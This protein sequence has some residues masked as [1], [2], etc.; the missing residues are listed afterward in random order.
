MAAWRNIHSPDP[1][2]LHLKFWLQLAQ[3]LLRRICFKLS[4]TDADAYLYCELTMSLHL[5]WA[6]NTVQPIQEKT[7]GSLV[8]CQWMTL[9]FDIHID[10]CN[11]LV[12]CIC[13]FWHHRL[14]Q[15]LEISGIETTVL[16]YLGSEQQR[17]WS[18][19]ADSQADLSLCCSHMA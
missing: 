13:Q 18:D 3:W 9:T 11:H 14:Y 12:N 10:S 5:R 17:R 7:I 16:Y 1:W 6:K 2:R 4:T 15:R 19:C 8:L